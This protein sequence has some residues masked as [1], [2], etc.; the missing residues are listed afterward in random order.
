M[1]SFSRVGR[2]NEKRRSLNGLLPLSSVSVLL[3]GCGGG[4]SGLVRQDSVSGNVVA[5]P[6]E[7]AFVFIDYDDDG[8][9]DSDSEPSTRTALDGSFELLSTD[10]DATVVAVADDETRQAGES[11]SG[12]T[13]K[14]PSGASVVSPV[15]TLIE[16][17][18]LDADDVATALGMDGVDLLNFNPFD[19]DANADD[20][21]K[22]EE[23]A[24]QLVTTTKLLSDAVEGSGIESSLAQKSA[25]SSIG[26]L[27][28]NKAAGSTIDLTSDEDLD[29]V[30]VLLVSEA[31]SVAGAD[32]N[33]E[34]TLESLAP[35]L[36]VMAKEL[37][38]A[39]A[40]QFDNISAGQSVS[41][42]VAD[43]SVRNIMSSLET[44]GSR[45]QVAAQAAK[46]EAVENE[47]VITSVSLDT[48]V[49]SVVS[50]AQPS[51]ISI[52]NTQ[53]LE[54]T[55][56]KT[57]GVLSA[58]DAETTDQSNFIFSISGT[59]SEL[60][61]LDASNRSI[62]LVALP[63]YEIQASY[64]LTIKATDEGGKSI[65]KGITVEVIDVIEDLIVDESESLDLSSLNTSGSAD[66]TVVMVEGSSGSELLLGSGADVVYVDGSVSEYEL[67]IADF[68]IGIDSIAHGLIKADGSKLTFADF[69]VEQNTDGDIVLSSNHI[70]GDVTFVLNSVLGNLEIEQIDSSIFASSPG[71]YG[72]NE[73]FQYG[74][75]SGDPYA[76]SVVLWTHATSLAST[77][78]TVTVGWEI[79]TTAD[80]SN[81]VDSGT[82]TTDASRDFTVKVIADGLNAGQDYFYRFHANGETSTVG[83][84]KTLAEGDV[85][86]VDFAVFSCANYPAGYFNPYQAAADSAVDYDALVFLGDFIYEYAN[87]PGAY[88]S[89]YAA[90][91]G[92]E[93]SPENELVSLD[94]Y[95]LRY[96]TYN[97]DESL[98][99]LRAKAPSIMMWDD[100]ETA[101]DS[102]ATGA[103]NHQ[104]DSEGLWSD[105]VDAAMQAYYEWNPIREPVSGELYENYR[106]FD[107]GDLVSLH[108]LETR[109]TAR[110]EQLSLTSPSENVLAQV[111]TILSDAESAAAVLPAYGIDPTSETVA[112]ELAVALTLVEVFSTDQNMVGEQQ[113]EWLQSEMTTSTA[114]YQVIGS[115]TLM[116]NMAIPLTLAQATADPTSPEA[117]AAFA[118]YAEALVTYATTGDPTAYLALNAETK[119]PYN[120]DAWDGYAYEQQVILATAVQNQQKLITLAGDTHNA[121]HSELK[122]VEGVDGLPSDVLAGYEFATPGVSAPGLEAYFAQ[123]PPADVAAFFENYVT[124]VQ[125]ANTGDRGF[126]EMSFTDDA[127]SGQFV[128]VDTVT[129]TDFTTSRDAS[130]LIT[131][132]DV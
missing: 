96:S 106:S 32:E 65:S 95:R 4:G 55:A 67:D 113:L 50:N 61:E 56:D 76:D 40:T 14:A 130:D 57:I 128:Y 115:Q 34:A 83:Q 85:S 11:F 73:T 23:I 1:M 29:A 39:I 131:V 91:L 81:V 132:Y 6:L 25:Y 72:Y 104:P 20:A 12:F 94:D 125:Y 114:E 16:E 120:L 117:I 48:D 86:A 127:V 22:A 69:S 59:D 52:S 66:A 63:D 54:S 101:N 2:E 112:Q 100:H 17:S 37:N 108:M 88:A 78:E 118:P 45:V 82:T 107:F 102:Y 80:F 42:I 31:Q 46:A 21:L 103:Q 89:A 15:S 79:S 33:V 116:A 90:E 47:G 43:S 98:Q 75:A 7:D 18:G 3:V 13:F 62:S 93:V 110:D 5:S 121:W 8:L 27:I 10:S 123:L 122:T 70:G 84:T 36:K 97:G 87:D 99:A 35:S 109:L 64:S 71:L 28:S 26:K 111:Q 19:D 126:L 30:Q 60:F 129:S 41:D 105:R 92:R 9:H 44:I 68:S 77:I 124:D 38:Q 58:V 24:Q 53:I 74:I 119:V 51:S 49:Q